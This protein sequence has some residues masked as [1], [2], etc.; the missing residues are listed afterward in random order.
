MMKNANTVKQL[1]ENKIKKGYIPY[2]MGSKCNLDLIND[3]PFNLKIKKIVL[4]DPNNTEFFNAYLTINGLAFGKKELGM[5]NWVALDC[6]CLPSVTVGFAKK[7]ETLPK[8]LSNKMGM[9]KKGQ[10]IPVSEYTLLPKINQP[11]SYINCTL[12]SVIPKKELA[13]LS[14]LLGIAIY[15]AKE[16]DIVAQYFD[17]SLKT[18]SKYGNIEIITP[19]LKVHNLKNSF[20]GKLKINSLTEICTNFINNKKEIDLKDSKIIVLEYKLGDKIN[21]EKS[22]FSIKYPGV[23]FNDIGTEI[24]STILKKEDAA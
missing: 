24:E 4:E 2:V 16:I 11:G 15:E 17:I 18:H 10:L 23:K 9:G 7:Y 3:A 12:C 8:Q 20:V 19:Q 22:K 5:P 21:L 13:S 6:V 1:I 14:V